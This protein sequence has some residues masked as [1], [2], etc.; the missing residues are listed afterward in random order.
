MPP[1]K[2]SDRPTVMREF[3]D[4]LA[5][6]MVVHKAME[7]FKKSAYDRARSELDDRMRVLLYSL[8]NRCLSWA[9]SLLL[10]RPR[11]PDRA[12]RVDREA[13]RLLKR[14]RMKKGTEG[15]EQSHCI[16][17]AMINA[18][19]LLKREQIAQ[20]CAVVRVFCSTLTALLAWLYLPTNTFEIFFR[21]S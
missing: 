18:A 8:E 17:S 19:G 2:N 11:D 5:E 21:R 4:I 15:Y 3:G 14:M 1:L 10:G 13:E 9:K 12:A 6:H 16:L 7:G 20:G